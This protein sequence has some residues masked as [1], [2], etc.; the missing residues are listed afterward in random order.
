M[1]NVPMPAMMTADE[2]REA[3]LRFFQ[4]RGHLLV[5]SAPLIPVGDPTLLLTSAGMVPFK[6]YFTGEAAPPNR[7]LT[8]CQKC[9]RTTDI[10]SV[11]DSTH[12]TFFEML[13]NFS[14]GDYFKKEAIA[15][16]WE[17][18]TQILKLPQERFSI[19]IYTDD[20][21]AFR[22][23]QDVGVPPGRIY[24]FGEKHNWWGP[25]GAEGPCGPC[26]ELHYDLG[27][28]LGCGRSECGP[29]CENPTPAGRPCGRF[30]ELWNLV[31]TQFYHH[32]DGTRTP[33]P[34]PNIDTGM[35]LE[36]T[37]AV[38]QGQ[39]SVYDTDLFA[40][41]LK[42]VSQICGKPYGQKEDT[43]Y[44]LRVVA[45]HS[46]SATFLIADGVVPGNEG[47]G[48]VLR[49]VIRRAIRHGRRLG[50]EGP[51]LGQVAELIIREMDY[52]YPELRRHQAFILKVLELEEEQF[53]GILAAQFGILDSLISARPEIT[54]LV[55]RMRV[56]P[57]LQKGWPYEPNESEYDIGHDSILRY[58]AELRSSRPRGEIGQYDYLNLLLNIG[59]QYFLDVLQDQI[60]LASKVSKNSDYL[61]LR[62]QEVLASNWEGS[63]TRYEVFR[64]YD[65]YGFPVEVTAEIA[66]EH[67]LEVDM[68]GFQREMEAQ[69]E[70]GRAS[71]KFGGERAKIRVYESL[72][73]GATQFLG[74]ET[75]S[76][77]SVVVGLIAGGEVVDEAKEGQEVEVVLRETP[78]YAEMG[79]QVGDVGVIS[80]PSSKVRVSD[81]QHGLPDMIVHIGVVVQGTISLGETVDARVDSIHRENTA[82]NHT[83]TH[84][85]HAALRQVLGPHVRQAGSLVAP[86]R[87]RFDFSHVSPLSRDELLMVQRLVNEKIRQNVSVHKREASYS[88]A[89]KEGALAFF[90]DKYSEMVRVVEVA[91]GATFSLEVCGGTHIQY[92]GEI[93]ACYILSESSIGSGMRRI[94]AVTGRVAESLVSERFALLDGVS[95][96]LQT[97]VA[98]LQARVKALLEEMEQQRKRLETMERS[99]ARQAAEG[100]LASVQEIDG[101]KLLAA[102]VSVSSQ[103]AMREM[104]D[105]IR[106]KLGSG[107]VVLGAVVDDRPSLVAMVTPDL[108]SKGYS[109]SEIV[110]GAAKAI[111]GGGGGRPEL[112]QAGGRRKEKLDEALRLVLALVRQE[113]GP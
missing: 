22:Y 75:M 99:V 111:E 39:T 100:L 94:E 33:L 92:T 108:V 78:F 2:I 51:F 88:A 79:G 96:T 28:E 55:N 38:M 90:G 4:E 14:I 25:A 67:G 1:S 43:D 62:L 104:G 110:R 71:A 41:I 76:S 18:V 86:D 85:L 65:T 103:D 64:L 17:F 98:E 109:A 11:G 80:G 30:V 60:V 29:N 32:L 20:D 74:Y 91:N 82:R 87:L 13:G 27:S 61:R 19:T 77:H 23:W 69:R 44:A 50:L 3:Y 49:R 93:G 5:P 105:W 26:S 8:S 59:V 12:L 56:D 47:R 52:Q 6:P 81:T 34:A 16:A 48:Y 31:F 97:P 53:G 84:L 113:K 40:A 106:D 7:R 107:I 70:R 101:V 89:I 102:K 24:R 57:A 42:T 10:D 35:G 15:W 112:A 36:R 37:A 21:E 45:E 46:R 58:D 9:F 54:R 66:R 63:I 72:G 73:V 95:Q 68:E 83:A